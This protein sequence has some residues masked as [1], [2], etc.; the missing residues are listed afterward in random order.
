[1]TRKKW[2]TLGVGAVVIALFAAILLTTFNFNQ[3]REEI[4][5]DYTNP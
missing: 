3:E 2:I 5:E 1:M 4:F